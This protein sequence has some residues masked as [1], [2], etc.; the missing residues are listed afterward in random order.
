MQ[1]MSFTFIAMQSIP[2]VSHRRISFATRTFVPTLSVHRESAYDP[3]STRPVKCPIFVRGLPRPRR[4]Y[5][6]AETRAP[7]WVA[8][9]SWLTPAS[10]YVRTTPHGTG[11]SY[12]KGARSL[13]NMLGRHSTDGLRGGRTG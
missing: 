11:R 7:M 3:K 5:R 1:I 9:S 12:F 8:F 4:R 6:R 10:A 13:V 2:I